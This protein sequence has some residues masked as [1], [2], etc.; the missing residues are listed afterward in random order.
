MFKNKKVKDERIQN[1]YTKFNSEGF[2]IV[3]A[4]LLGLYLVKSAILNLPFNTYITEFSVFLVGC[5]YVALRMII[6]GTYSIGSGEELSKSQKFKKILALSVI[7]GICFGVALSII[8]YYRYDI[9]SFEHLPLTTLISGG[10]FIIIQTGLLWLFEIYSEK[11][12]K[13]QLDEL[14]EDE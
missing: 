9:G 2:Y 4:L 3:M 8:N 5:L 6:S 13:K 7:T 10:T 1:L 11:R 14:E 12:M